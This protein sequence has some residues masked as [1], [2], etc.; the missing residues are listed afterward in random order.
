[1]VALLTPQSGEHG[2][3]GD[4]GYTRDAL[5]NVSALSLPD[6]DT[7]RWL[8]Y[9]SGHVSAVKFNHQVVSEFTRDRLHRE[10]SRTQGRR[11]QQRAYDSLGR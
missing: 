4:I 3:E 1:M 10:I 2:S 8:R 5:G 11:T 9:G 6:G 7:L